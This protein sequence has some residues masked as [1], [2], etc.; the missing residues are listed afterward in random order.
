[1]DEIFLLKKACLFL[2]ERNDPR[3]NPEKITNAN[4]RRFSNHGGGGAGNKRHSIPYESSKDV[5]RNIQKKMVSGPQY[6][7][8][9]RN[10]FKMYDCLQ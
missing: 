4:N 6:V 5:E 7:D 9:T 8:L 2:H 1:V 10:C 3:H